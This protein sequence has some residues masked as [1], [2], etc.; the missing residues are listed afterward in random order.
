MLWE[1]SA[2][3]TKW[4]P[5]H[6]NN[7]TIR[8]PLDKWSSAITDPELKIPVTLPFRYAWTS[9]KDE[10]ICTLIFSN[11]PAT[12]PGNGFII[13]VP[14][15]FKNSL[16]VRKVASATASASGFWST[17]HHFLS[18]ANGTIALLMNP[19]LDNK[20][21][22]GADIIRRTWTKEHAQHETFDHL[23]YRT[24][25]ELPVVSPEGFLQI[26][27]TAEMNEFDLLLAVVYLPE[28]RSLL[29]P[30]WIAD[31]MKQ[32]GTVALENNREAGI[33][34]FQDE[35]ILACLNG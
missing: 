9:H 20:D 8:Y 7:E 10:S 11:H 33:R 6:F 31:R 1:K 25:N 5:M 3:M 28:E 16:S 19:D 26:P 30:E 32:S 17:D 21:K 13:P 4:R 12:L 14:G 34:T 22:T 27:W 35:E 24:T 23:Q 15:E 29:T 2:S 18:N